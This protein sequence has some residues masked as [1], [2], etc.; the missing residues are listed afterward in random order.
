M[1]EQLHLCNKITTLPNVLY[2]KSA[3]RIETVGFG[4][5]VLFSSYRV[6]FPNKKNLTDLSEDS[7]TLIQRE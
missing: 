7:G 2:L 5:R 1:K 4:K 6:P 3:V